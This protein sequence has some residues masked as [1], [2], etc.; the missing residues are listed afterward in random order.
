MLLIFDNNSNL[1]TVEE[2][3]WLGENIR[4]SGHQILI[5]GQVTYLTRLYGAEWKLEVIWSRLNWT[6]LSILWNQ[7]RSFILQEVVVSFVWPATYLVDQLELQTPVVR[8]TTGLTPWSDRS[9]M[10]EDSIPDWYRPI[11]PSDGNLTL[12]CRALHERAKPN[13]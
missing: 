11:S 5:K 12:C 4:L 3:Q 10:H 13:A 2:I 7:Q 6:R 9:D 1:G 8:S